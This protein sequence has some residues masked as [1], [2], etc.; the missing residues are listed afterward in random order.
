[1]L[2]FIDTGTHNTWNITRVPAVGESIC[3]VKAVDRDAGPNGDVRY[4]I[5]Y[6]SINTQTLCIMK[7]SRHIF[8]FGCT[9][10]VHI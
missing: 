8:N 3:L 7:F 6:A 1:M 4:S 5:Q 2:R 10:A 9:C